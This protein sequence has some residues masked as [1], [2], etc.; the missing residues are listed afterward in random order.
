[1]LSE[2]SHFCLQIVLKF[3][4]LPNSASTRQFGPGFLK[5]HLT[6][7]SPG[8]LM[9]VDV[10]SAGPG[11]DCTSSF[12]V[13]LPLVLMLPWP[14]FEQER[15]RLSLSLFKKLFAAFNPSFLQSGLLLCCQSNLY[16]VYIWSP[17]YLASYPSVIPRGFQNEVG[18]YDWSSLTSSAFPL[19][20]SPYP[21]LFLH[22]PHRV[23]G[24]KALA[25]VFLLHLAGSPSVPLASVILP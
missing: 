2:Y 7:R 12:Q 18:S 17:Q 16:D 25:P 6:S 4:P 15:C 20:H 8:E 23:Y 10:D 24:G 21:H 3:V 1:M 19:W 14:Y 22:T 11:Q 13:R 9:T 5:L